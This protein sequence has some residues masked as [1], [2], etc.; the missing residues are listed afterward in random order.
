MK[1]EILEIKG[2]WKSIKSAALET[3]GKQYSGK[4]IPTSWKRGMLLSEH[5]PIREITVTW[6]WIDLPYWIHVHLVRHHIGFQ[7]YV[8]T[9]RD[10]ING[11]QE[12]ESRKKKPQDSPV[13][14]R[15]SANLQSIINISRKRLCNKASAE[16]KEAWFLFLT[17]LK[18]HLPEVVEKCVPE[19]MYRGFCP[20][21]NSCGFINSSTYRYNL[22]KY[23]RNQ[24][25]TI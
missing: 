2:N 21:M 24:E 15:V 25:D 11:T 5:S 10:D 20:E 6:R 18:E 22:L 7:P 17:H 1:V 3:I 9:Q 19:C 16:T 4:E 8:S 12:H 23:R 13:T 14:M